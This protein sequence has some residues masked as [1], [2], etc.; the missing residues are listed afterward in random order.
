MRR[1]IADGRLRP[2][3]SCLPAR[4]CTVFK[5]SRTT[6]TVST[7]GLRREVSLSHASVRTYVSKHLAPIANAKQRNMTNPLKPR[8]VWDSL[9][10]RRFRR[11]GAIRL[12]TAFRTHQLFFFR[13][14]R[15]IV[16]LPRNAF[17][18]RQLGR[19]TLTPPPT[20]LARGHCSADRSS[21]GSKRRGTISQYHGAQQPLISSLVSCSAR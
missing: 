5:V 10:L 2:G 8:A 21:R 12:R 4:T 16:W 11:S 3:D 20:R 6:V 19:C 1:A 18:S 9:C 15:G 17:R 13:M 14:T 7:D